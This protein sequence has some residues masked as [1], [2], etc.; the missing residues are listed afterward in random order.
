MDIET[1]AVQE[2]PPMGAETLDLPTRSSATEE[3]G[4]AG[5]E[6]PRLDSTGGVVTGADANQ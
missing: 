6:L 1:H 2:L 4:F 3:T 5:L